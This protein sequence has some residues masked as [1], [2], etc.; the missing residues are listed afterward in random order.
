[1]K[2]RVREIRI[3]LGAVFAGSALVAGALCAALAATRMDL[4]LNL[5]FVGLMLGLVLPLGL[6]IRNHASRPR[7]VL[8]LDY[9]SH[10]YGQAVHRGVRSVLDSDDEKRSWRVE[11]RATGTP[12]ADGAV[13]WQ[14]REIQAAIHR[15]IDGLVLIPA[16]DDDHLW[17]AVAKAIKAGHMFVTAVD[18]KPPNKF[19]YDIAVEPPRFV[20]A[21]YPLTGVLTGKLLEE[22]M[23]ED[24]AR[25]C[26]LWT[27]PDGSWPGEERSRNIIYVL[28][29]AGLLDRTLLMP[30]TAWTPDAERCA[31]AL[32]V[33]EASKGSVAV[34]CADDENAMALH[35][36]TLTEQPAL[37]SRMYI[38]GCNGT[39]DD[40]GNVVAVDMRA[41]DATIDILAESQGAQV[42]HWFVSERSGD[43][44]P[45][46]RSH[47]VEP[48]RLVRSPKKA[49]WLDA[50][51]DGGAGQ[52]GE[53]IL[54]DEKPMPNTSH[55][56]T[57]TTD[58]L[59]PT[60]EKDKES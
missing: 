42:A 33:I 57:F 16:G 37:R 12:S 40:Y 52:G 55:A 20:S 60:L 24:T 3:P 51:L 8:V 22:W 29:Q 31:D 43:L 23:R 28:A 26:I 11:Y 9:R 39:P 18:T 5:A 17:H 58:F 25:S 13:E 6:E 46:E 49:R 10:Q 36:Y 59:I 54:V 4:G 50:L 44:S 45:S 32:R 21:R 48:R 56:D 47:F 15:K 19:Y 27:G 34:Y 53:T 30:I 1:M 14:V 35:I 7:R 41:V 38:V 2:S